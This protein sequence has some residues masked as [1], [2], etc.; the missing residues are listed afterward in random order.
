MVYVLNKDGKPLMPTERHGKVRRMLRDGQAK[1]VQRTPFTI[2]LLYDTTDY[3]QEITLGVDPGY[4]HIGLS[5]TTETKELYAADIQLRTDIV[6]NLST[7]REM[8]HTRRNR[9]TRFRAPR[10]FN[11][12]RG[13][14]WLPP[15]VRQR[16]EC[17]IHVI[18]SVCKILPIFRVVLEI[19]AFDIQKIE[20]PD[21][22]GAEYQNGPLKGFE[23]VRE[24]VLYRDNHTCQCCK[25]ENKILQVHHIESRKVGGDSPGNLITLCKECHEGYHRGEV[26]LPKNLKREASQKA[27]TCM[28]IMMP[29]LRKELES[30]FSNIDYTYGYITKAVRIA[31][32]LPK[33]HYIDARCISGH[34]LAKPLGYV[35]YELKVRCHNR[36]IHK[37]TARKGEHGVR[38]LNQCPREMFGFRLYDKVLFN[39]SEYFIWGRRKSGTFKICNLDRTETTERTYKKLKLIERSKYYLIERKVVG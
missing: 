21:I 5:A 32:G 34:P 30:R 20:N 33:E 3:I 1:V 15:S 13:R 16:I 22:H 28:N 29:T 4:E 17:H 12:A 27:A 38:R 19:A 10:F 39:K 23:N 35:F 6:D 9:K 26:K 18:E 2:Q 25:G 37:A 14:G 7:R 24:Y 8:R 31:A 36:Q 11:R